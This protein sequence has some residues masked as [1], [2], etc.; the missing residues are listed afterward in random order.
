MGNSLCGGVSQNDR[1]SGELNFYSWGFVLPTGP[2][3]TSLL[4]SSLE[5]WLTDSK[6][7]VLFRFSHVPK[8]RRFGIFESIGAT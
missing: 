1:F 3:E 8:I 6:Q 4:S 7:V 2:Q 5:W